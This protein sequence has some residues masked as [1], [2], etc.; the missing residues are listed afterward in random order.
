MVFYNL[1]ITYRISLISG[2]RA[3]R[4][5]PQGF[6]Y[7]ELPIG[8]CQGIKGTDPK[9]GPVLIF[10]FL[11][12]FKFITMV[13]KFDSLDPLSGCIQLPICFDCFLPRKAHTEMVI[14][15]IERVVLSKCWVHGQGIG[16]RG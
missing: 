12:R 8:L 5:R 1:S 15:V 6:Q 10:I 13:Q 14:K 2:Q 7:I 4:Y 9:N 3:A 16:P 11:E